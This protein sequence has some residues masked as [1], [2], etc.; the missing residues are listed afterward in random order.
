MIF[1]ERLMAIGTSP[2]CLTGEESWFSYFHSETKHFRMEWNHTVSE[3]KKEARTVTSYGKSV[4]KFSR[5][6]RCTYWSISCPERKLSVQFA[7]FSHST[8]CDMDYV[9][10]P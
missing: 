3:K 9:I 2:I 10:S 4:G 5:I 7:V 8:N 1:G 6:P